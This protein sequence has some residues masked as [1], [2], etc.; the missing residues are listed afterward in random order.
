MMIDKSR[1]AGDDEGLVFSESE[2]KAIIAKYPSVAP[3]IKTILGGDEFLNNTPRKCLWAPTGLSKTVAACPPLMDRINKVRIWRSSSGRKQTKKLAVTPYR[4][5]EIRQPKSYYI[6]VPKVS[7][8]RRFY[9]PIALLDPEIIASGSALVID[10]GTLYQFGILQSFMHNSWMRAVAGR[11]KSDYQYSAKVVYNN[12]VWPDSPTDAQL[13]AVETASQAILS[14][15]KSHVGLSLAELYDP[16]KMPLI[17]VKA[18]E[19]LDR[20]VDACYRKQPFTS[21]MERVQFLF[22]LYEQKTAPLAAIT[23]GKSKRKQKKN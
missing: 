15:R 9:I 17:L 12:F 23:S 2:A 10:E 16:L 5:G 3:D 1:K 11:M 7:S 14:A 13:K 19:A 21:E 20:A 6:F 18:H 22:K 4:F 8:Q